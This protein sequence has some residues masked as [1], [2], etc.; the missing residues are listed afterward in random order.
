M[1]DTHSMTSHEL[2]LAYGD[3]EAAYQNALIHGNEPQR[4]AGFTRRQVL[5]ME[6]MNRLK[7]YDY[8]IQQWERCL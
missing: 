2:V 4:A 1:I 7:H 6:L 8:A 5:E 3:A